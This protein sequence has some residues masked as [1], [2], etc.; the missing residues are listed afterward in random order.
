M[1]TYQVTEAERA[2]LDTA[3]DLLA[4]YGNGRRVLDVLSVWAHSPAVSTDVGRLWGAFV[5]ALTA[6]DIEANPDRYCDRCQ[7]LGEVKALVPPCCSG[8]ECGC[9][10]RT[11]EEVVAC[12]ECDGRQ[13]V[14]PRKAAA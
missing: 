2:A 5:D 10:G 14:G 1:T 3:S 9:H 8:R 6:M 4:H 12:P 7:G 13:Y 11:Q